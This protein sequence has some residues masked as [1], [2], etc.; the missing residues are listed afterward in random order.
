MCGV[1]YFSA[2]WE[3]QAIRQSLVSKVIYE[4]ENCLFI[5]AILWLFDHTFLW[6][7]WLSYRFYFL[8]LWMFER[9]KNKFCYPS[10]SFRKEDTLIILLSAWDRS[11]D[12]T[13][14]R[15]FVK[16]HVEDRSQITF[17]LSLNQCHRSEK[18]NTQMQIVS[19]TLVIF[20][21]IDKLSAIFKPSHSINQC[22]RSVKC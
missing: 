6:K 21:Q 17:Q 2:N 16:G 11:R 3:Q 9:Q 1:P 19:Q 10:L 8:F 18:S 5:V 12:S 22:H 4:N 7:S 13:A 15:N 20:I 14:K